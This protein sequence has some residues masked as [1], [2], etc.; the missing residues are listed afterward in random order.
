MPRLGFNWQ[1][2]PEEFSLSGDVYFALTPAAVMAGGHLQGEWRSGSV[3]AW[4]KAGVDFLIA[5]KPY[6]YDATAYIDIGVEVTFWLFGT[7]RLS[8]DV[9]ADLHIWG[10]RFAGE[11]TIHL[12]IISFTIHFGDSD[13][14][15]PKAIGWR[16]FKT[17]FLPK[18][19]E[20]CSIAV[21]DGLVRKGKD[22][23]KNDLGFI[24][25][26]HFC[27]VT[28]SRIPST[29]ASHGGTS[30][31]S[32]F[33]IAPVGIKEVSSSTHTITITSNQTDVGGRFVYTPVTKNV[34]AALWGGSLAPTLNGPQFVENALTGFKISAKEP[35]EPDQ[36]LKIKRSN[37]L[38]GQS[39]A[40]QVCHWGKEGKAFKP[41][42]QLKNDFGTEEGMK[43]RD[44][45]LK[46]LGIK[47]DGLNLAKSQTYEFMRP[48]QSE[49]A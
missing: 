42:T 21:A 22:D 5:W 34:P 39:S 23:D 12:W 32:K 26:K 10:P 13:A 16:D 47:L 14:S 27:L 35:K 44:A 17:S 18:D 37:L 31:G 29:S 20:V 6:H 46:S 49:A 19:N 1:V 30:T 2:V 11:A 3:Y 15:K 25:G 36:T 24:N 8:L 38:I 40:R 9:G 48:P 4:F 43:K 33:G 41:G 7:Q 45:L 28:D